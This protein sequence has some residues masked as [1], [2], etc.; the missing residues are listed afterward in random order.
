MIAKSRLKEYN[1]K[2]TIAAIATPLAA[3]ALGVI[4]ISGRES[5]PIIS[6]IFKSVK[7]KNLKTAKTFTLHYGWIIERPKIKN[8]KSKIVDEVLVSVMKAPNSY[9]KEDVVE[10]SCHGGVVILDKILK[11]IL[12]HGSR[13][14]LPGEFTYRALINGRIDLLQ[15]EGVAAAIEAKTSQ[16]LEEASFQL[17]GLRSKKTLLLKEKVKDL[18]VETESLINFPEEEAKI[19]YSELEKKIIHLMKEFK[20]LLSGS[21]TAKIL[22]EGIRCVICGKANAGKSTLFNRLLREE[23][24]IVSKI[25]GTTRDVIEE[26]IQ[27]KGLPLRIFDTAGILEPGDLIESQ[28]IDKANEIFSQADLVIMVLDGFKKLNSQDYLLL[29]KAKDKNTLVVINKSDL[30]QKIEIKKILP[31]GFDIVKMSALKNI[32]LKDLEDS[33]YRLVL[34]G[35]IKRENLIFLNSYQQTALETAQQDLCRALECLKQKQ[36]I[37]FINICLKDCLESLGRLN[38]EVLTEEILE[39]IF[40]RFCIGK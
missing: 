2:D 5:L 23:R 25:P 38:G 4:K 15:A 37:D 10:V 36:T 32:G 20:G 24:V 40:G 31:F 8:Q 22:R 28:A 27:V 17:Q 39:S 11:L 19:S 13:M 14:A 34:S 7:N 35:P 29:N 6:K 16:A 12:K 33:I 18:F 30:V 26:T 9:T 21:K 1:S 3:S